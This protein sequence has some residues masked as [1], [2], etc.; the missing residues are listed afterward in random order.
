ML[1]VIIPASNEEAWIGPC[2]RAVLASDPVPGGA[3]VVVVANGCRDGTASLA[4]A[5]PVP[6]GWRV[7]VI[8]RAEGSKPGALDA[9]DAAATPGAARVYLDAD[10]VVSPPLLAQLAGVLTREA[11][12]YAGGTPVIPRARS[13]LTRA[14]G[15]F[16]QRLPFAR[17][18]AP[19]YGLYAV[20]AAG[21]ARWGG[22]PRIIS[23]DG[24]VRLH[25]AP[26]ERVQV[27]ATYAWP[28]V[29][30]WAALVRT[31][32]RQDAGMRELAALHP[33]LMANEGKEALGAGGLAALALR[34]PAGFAAYGAV[35]LAV[36][37]RRGGAGFTRGR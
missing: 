23:D 26:A 24:F 22:F 18:V 2:L 25:F 12:V 17:S 34:D 9:G 1:S 29:E 20:N 27:P 28:M 3:E 37:L 5:V 7:E 13:A 32:R 6:A 36:R 30:G 33:G 21:R 4:R 14:Y 15:R 16:W 10:C 8:E 19:G 31:R 35:S 11:P